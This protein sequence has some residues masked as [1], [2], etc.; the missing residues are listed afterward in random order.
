MSDESDSSDDQSGGD[1]EEE[2]EE[3]EEDEDDEENDEAAYDHFFRSLIETANGFDLDAGT[4]TENPEGLCGYFTHSLT[5]YSHE[6][7]NRHLQARHAAADYIKYYDYMRSRQ[8]NPDTEWD[9]VD[10]FYERTQYI[11]ELQKVLD[12]AAGAANTGGQLAWHALSRLVHLINL[13]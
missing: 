3:E 8:V 7:F 1:F 2:V 6:R 10:M 5:P 11:N 13:T 12:G 4:T 9:N